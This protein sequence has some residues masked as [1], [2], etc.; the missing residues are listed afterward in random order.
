MAYA[1]WEVQPVRSA[2]A[3]QQNALGCQPAG[4]PSCQSHV[5]GAAVSQLGPALCTQVSGITT[6][7]A[8]LALL[9]GL[10]EVSAAQDAPSS[11][12]PVSASSLPYTVLSRRI[13][14]PCKQQLGPGSAPKGFGSNNSCIQATDCAPCALSAASNCSWE[15][16]AVS[17][18]SPCKTGMLLQTLKHRPAIS[19]AHSL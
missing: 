7:L 9:G 19:W 17:R 2:A 12:T 16:R 11:C 5:D 8:L 6:T 15:S 13:S 14:L 4:A 10:S 3:G 18:R 1:A